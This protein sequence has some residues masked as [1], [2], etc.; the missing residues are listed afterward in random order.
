MSQ[1]QSN[2]FKPTFLLVMQHNITG[3]KYFCKTTCKDRV[4]RYKGSGVAWTK[5]LKEFGKDITVG[6]LGFYTDAKRCYEA[7]A[8]FT[9]DNDIVNSKEWANIIPETGKNGASLYG[10]KNPFYGKHHSEE[11][12]QKIK[13][14]NTGKSYNKGAYR[15]P[16]QRA[17]ISA[18]L[19]G[20]KNPAVSKALT[21]R[22]LSE[23]TKRKIGEGGKG[24]VFSME[25]REKIRQAALAQWARQKNK[26]ADE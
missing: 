2:T 24:R 17:K 15:S 11:T 23:E 7:A 13:L 21:G 25:A 19:K 4:Y 1:M 26:P 14:A 9:I 3:L 22:K 16:E 12:K 10:N 20:R 8:K 6:V 18:A 5:H